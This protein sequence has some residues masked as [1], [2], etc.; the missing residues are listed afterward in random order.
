MDEAKD[1]D[2]K[3]ALLPL[4]FDGGRYS[5]VGYPFDTASELSNYQKLLV[6]VAKQTWREAN[7]DRQRL[8]RN[9]VQSLELRLTVVG[10]GSV[11]PYAVGGASASTQQLLD[12][13]DRI[14]DIFAEIVQK[15]FLPSWLSID[16]R[17]AA[18]RVGASLRTDERVFLNS[19]T[20]DRVEYTHADRA[21][22]VAN[23][24]ARNTP[25]NG[26]L[27]GKAVEIDP[28]K[29]SFQIELS[30]GSKVHARF[31]KP[32][33][34]QTIH[35]FVSPSAEANVVRFHARYLQSA[36]GEVLVVEDV[37]DVEEFLESTSAWTPRLVEL[38]KL[39]TGWLDGAG[40]AITLAAIEY[41]NAILSGLEQRGITGVRVYPTPQGGVQLEADKGDRYAELVISED[42][43]MEGYL[44]DSETDDEFSPQTPASAV[45]LI[46]EALNG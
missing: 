5:Q 22:M 41:S 19:R 4:S 37:T 23:E 46:T 30:D 16:A 18:L 17:K 9:F 33:L 12:H 15:G 45:D 38:L 28:D 20:K 44:S 21:L 24:E 3:G 6:E 39:K 1:E 10:K 14:R 31:S 42:L 8:P 36:A 34:W 7:P 2:V 43:V 40:S 11:L 26:V 35:N 13:F 25:Q 29:Q 27:A 32:D